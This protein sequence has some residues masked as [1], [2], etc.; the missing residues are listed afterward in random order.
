M[1]DRPLT[2]ADG[3][4]FAW[5]VLALIGFF[6]AVAVLSNTALGAWPRWLCADQY[7]AVELEVTRYTHAAAGGR[8]KSGG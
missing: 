6:T 3:I 7:V 8:R 4:A 2:L 1:K 5:C